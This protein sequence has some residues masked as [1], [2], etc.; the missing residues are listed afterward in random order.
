MKSIKYFSLIVIIGLLF[1]CSKK[2]DTPDPEVIPSMTDLIVS[3]DFNWSAGLTGELTIALVNPLNVSVEREYIQIIDAQ[4]RVLDRTLVHDS[5]ATFNLNLP[6]NANYYV[7]FPVTDDMMPIDAPGNL[8]MELGPTVE[9]VYP[10]LKSTEVVTCTA[11]DSP[12][13]NAGGEEPYLAS[14]WTLFNETQV[15]GWETTAT[16]GKIEVWANGF[17][18]VPAQE[19]HQFFELNANQVAALYQ[20]LCLEPGSTIYWSVWHRGRSGVDVADVKIG[21]TVETAEY[22][23]TMSDGKTAWGY[24]SGSYNVPAG[25]TT[26]VFVFNSVSAAGGNQ[27]IGNFLD[28]FEIS[29]DFDGDGIIDRWDDLPD[30]PNASF[31]SYFPESGKQIVAFE[32]LWPSYGDFDFNDLIL[33]NQVVITSNGSGTPLEASFKISIDA[34]G[35]S[36]DNGFAMMFYDINKTGFTDN[37]IAEITGD[38]TIDPDNANGLIITNDVFETINDRYQNNGEGPEGIPDTLRFTV[39]FN[40][41]AAPFIPELYLFRTN[42]RG[43]EV[44]RSGFPL[45]ATANAN[46]F[47][48]D[49]DAGD[50]KSATG[51]PW[52]IEI[53]TDVIYRNPIEKVDI[54]VAY[55]KFGSWATSNGLD[56]PTWYLEPVEDKVVDIDFGK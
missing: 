45:T 35:A 5:T 3:T 13:V 17:Q 27:S 21:A 28:N 49:N 11:C 46:L 23:A 26:T 48:T 32:D 44:H 41:N 14:G 50:Y 31:I 37:I 8:T 7:Y 19:G 25:Q 20:E 2:N 52:G 42:D 36:I 16:D 9:Y 56:N 29:C 34:I 10:H 40:E 24:Y 12:L 33:S 18:N 1:S 15:P 53:L 55:P 54:L 39:T 47:N 22:Q 43:H 38:A 51:L 30:D 6:G 4:G